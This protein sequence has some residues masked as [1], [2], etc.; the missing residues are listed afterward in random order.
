MVLA[1]SNYTFEAMSDLQADFGPS[2]PDE[3][4]GGLLVLA[5]PL[6]GCSSLSLP[7]FIDDQPWVALIARTQG[8]SD[9]CTFDVKVTS[10]P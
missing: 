6:D 2:V 8:R 4:I 10:T 5:D 1:V 9:D 7:D 3:G